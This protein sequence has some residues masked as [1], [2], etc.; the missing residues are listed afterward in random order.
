MKF[1]DG[2]SASLDDGLKCRTDATLTVVFRKLV[3]EQFE[4][5]RGV[6]EITRSIRTGEG[7]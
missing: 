2:E 6:D 4:L 1:H 5:T 3:Q 7:E